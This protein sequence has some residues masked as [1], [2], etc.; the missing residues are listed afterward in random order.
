MEEMVKLVIYVPITHAEVVREALGEAG[1]GHIGNYDHCSFSQRGTGR[2]RP[3]EGTDPFI[4]ELG[5]VEAVDEERIETVCPMRKA[6]EVLKAVR[7]V[8]PY[9]EMAYD[10]YP[11][12]NHEFTE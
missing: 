5:K 6:R 10:V 11:L 8:H 4:G 3:G 7:K 12:L 1:A 2:F 9:E